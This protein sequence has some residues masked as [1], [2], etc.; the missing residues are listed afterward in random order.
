[1]EAANGTFLLTKDQETVEAVSSALETDKQVTLTGVYSSLSEL[2]VALED[3]EVVAAMVDIDPDPSRM[4]AELDPIISRFPD[5]RFIVLAKQSQSELILEAM[6]VGARHVLV[7]ESIPENLNDV[8][9]QLIPTHQG[10]TRG[11]GSIITVLSG[12]GGSGA[13]T[14]AINLANEFGLQVPSPALVVDMDCVYGAVGHYLGL[15]AQYGL[16]DVLTHNGHIDEELIV[17]TSQAYSSSLHVLLSSDS[18]T[19]EGPS[20]FQ[21]DRLHG[22]LETFK[23]TYYHTV[24]D[25]GHVSMNV[26]ATLASAS[27]ATLLIFQ[28]NVKDLAVVSKLLRGLTRQGVSPDTILPV[29]NRY[30]NHG[31]GSTVTLEEAQRILGKTVEH[32]SND[33]SGALRGIDRGQPLSEAAPRSSLRRDIANLAS[34]LVNPSAMSECVTQR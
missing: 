25:S 7:K 23:N 14:V 4:L 16:Q 27:E 30:R 22:A 26:A 17:S 13:T 2:V 10:R 8:L 33:Y 21:R 3:S 11:H 32:M 1:M 34:R 6:H 28:L 19:D 15:S 9:G 5:T 12:S 18:V 20:P 24:I 31:H 29:A